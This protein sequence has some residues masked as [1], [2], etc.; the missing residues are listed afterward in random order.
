M[1]VLAIITR[2]T[3][4]KYFEDAKRKCADGNQ[5]AA[6]AA[7]NVPQG[8]ARTMVSNNKTVVQHGKA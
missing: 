1:S 6:Q 8:V 3:L 4:G 7:N 5:H 2:G